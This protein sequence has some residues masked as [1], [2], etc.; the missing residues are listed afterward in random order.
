MIIALY[1][2]LLLAVVLCVCQCRAFRKSYRTLHYCDFMV[3]LREASSA[4]K[5]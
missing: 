1:Q 3:F 2:G 5:H 4:D